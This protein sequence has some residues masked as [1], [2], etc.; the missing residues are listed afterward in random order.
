MIIEKDQNEAEKDVENQD[1]VDNK[2]VSDINV[3]RIAN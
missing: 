1:Q 2:S 3:S